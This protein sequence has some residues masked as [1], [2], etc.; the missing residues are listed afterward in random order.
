MTV[1]VQ[2]TNLTN[3]FDFWRGRTNELATAVSTLVITTNSN[4]TSG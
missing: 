2:N 3:T 4:T 1:I